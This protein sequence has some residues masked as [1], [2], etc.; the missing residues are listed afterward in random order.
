[1]AGDVPLV[2]MKWRCGN[3]G[4]RLTEFIVGGSHRRAGGKPSPY[5]QA[6]SQSPR[7]A[8]RSLG[9]NPLV[10]RVGA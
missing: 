8:R 5:D 7:H 1:V 4:T 3:C 9:H 6:P 2:Q 10:R